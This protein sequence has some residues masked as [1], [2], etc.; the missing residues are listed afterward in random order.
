ML[1][2]SQPNRNEDAHPREATHQAHSFPHGSRDASMARSPNQEVPPELD[3][4][5]GARN[6]SP[7]ESPETHHA[8]RR[9]TAIESPDRPLRNCAGFSINTDEDDSTEL[10]PTPGK[11][12]VWSPTSGRL[13]EKRSSVNCLPPLLRALN[14]E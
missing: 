13:Q 6:Q 2:D 9:K 14:F 11:N 3:Y 12:L 8:K 1:A 10:P 4:R 5:G 7:P